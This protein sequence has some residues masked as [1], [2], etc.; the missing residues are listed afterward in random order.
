M[1]VDNIRLATIEEI[2]AMKIDVVQRRGRKKDFWDLHELLDHYP[3]SLMLALHEQRYMHDHEEEII[4]SNFTNFELAD[5]DFNPICLRGKHW[6]FIKEDIQ[7]A[8]A[9]Y[10]KSK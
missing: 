8:V 10:K 1:V 2:V 6:E 4:L 9:E 7:D 3:L 5:E